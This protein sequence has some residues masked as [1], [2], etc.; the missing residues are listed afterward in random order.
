MGKLFLKGSELDWQAGPFP[1]TR[2]KTYPAATGIA[3]FSLVMEMAPG[4]TL[5]RHREPLNE[6]D[7][8]I[9]G[10]VEIEG[11]T[12]EAGDYMFTAAGEEHGPYRSSEGCTVFISKF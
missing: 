4:T 11:K 3:A 7:Y 1:G 2:M 5:E 10:S 9:S 6:V 12:L 8:V